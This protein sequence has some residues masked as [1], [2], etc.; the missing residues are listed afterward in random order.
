[1]SLSEERFAALESRLLDLE[2]EIVSLRPAKAWT[3]TEGVVIGARVRIHPTCSVIASDGRTVAIGDGVLLRRGAE[4]VGPVTIGS[5]SSFNR[6]VYIRANVSIGKNCNI[7]AF[8]RFISDSHEV[9]TS[10]RRAGRG[11]F[12]PIRIGDGTWVGAGSTILGGVTVGE[13][14]II[15]AGSVV[16]QNVPPNS[17][18]GGVPAK[19]I[20]VL[21]LES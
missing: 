4:I 16:T 11:S 3:R 18:V 13:S 9:G 6:D 14:C 12:E 7:G 21:P 5:G 19:L 15:A 10:T 17:M 2:A 1:M 8:C 20:K